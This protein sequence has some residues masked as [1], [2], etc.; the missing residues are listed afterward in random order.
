MLAGDRTPLFTKKLLALTV[1]AAGLASS[2][3]I[4]PPAMAATPQFPDLKVLPPRDLE[5]ARVNVSGG[6]TSAS[7]HHNV[8]RF[9]NTVWNSGD[10]DLRMRGV[11][12]PGE[13]PGPAFQRVMDDAGGFTERTA[14]SMVFHQQHDHYHYEGWGLYQLWT[15]A[16][17]DGWVSGGK[18]P[19]TVET[20]GAKTTSC[21]LDEEFIGGPANTRWPQQYRFSGCLANKNGELHEGLAVG[22]GDTYDS[23]RYDQ[24]IDLGATATL[25]DGEYVLRSV[26]DPGNQIWESP[27]GTDATREATANN[28]SIQRF[29]IAGG[30][31][32]DEDAPTGTVTLDDVATSTSDTSVTLKALGRDDVSGT[33]AFRVSNDNRTWS[34]PIA[35]SGYDSTPHSLAWNLADPQYGGNANPGTK[36]VYVQFRDAANRWGASETDT[37]DLV[38][39]GP[40]T[41]YSRTVRDDG[42]LSHWRLDESVATFGALDE[43]GGNHG[44][45]GGSPVIGAAGLLASEPDHKAVAFDGNGWLRFGDNSALDLTNRITLEAWV[46]P[47]AYPAGT[48]FA[49][50]LSKPEAYSLQFFGSQMEFTVITASGTSRGLRERLRLP[51]GAVPLN[52]VSHLV[53]TYDGATQ[54]LYVNGELAGERPLTLPAQATAT[55]IYVGSWDGTQEFFRG[56]IDEPAVY[57]TALSQSRT[58]AHYDAGK[59]AATAPAA[60]TNLAAADVSSS[61][62]DLTWTDNASDE[63]AF[64]LQRS[65]N[66]AFTDPVPIDVAEDRQAHSDTGLEPNRQYWYRILARNPVGPSNWSNVATAATRA[67]PPI[68]ENGAPG[69]PEE[70]TATVSGTVDPQGSATT[71]RFEYGPDFSSSTTAASAGSG[72]TAAPVTASLAGLQ[73]ATTYG[74]RLVATNSAGSTTSTSTGTFKTSSPAPTA[75]AAV[76]AA[77]TQV[78]LSWTDNSATETGFAAQRATD[79]SFSDAVDLPAV[80]GSSRSDAGL[81]PNK[82]YWYRVRA[83]FASGGES[84]WSAAQTV[85]TP[86]ATPTAS[87]SAASGVDETAGT[88]N[89]RV[90]PQGSATSY[91]FEHRRAGATSWSAGPDVAAGSGRANVA[92]TRQVT[93]LEPTTRYEFRIAATNSAGTTTSAPAGTFTTASPGAPSGLAAIAAS[94]TRIDLSWTDN[95]ISESGFVVE[96]ATDDGFTG[97]VSLPEVAGTTTSDTGLDPNRTYWY[98]VRARLPSGTTAWSGAA[99]RTT[100]AAPPTAVTGDAAGVTATGAT[101]AGS[102]DPRGAATTWWFEYGTG[103][104]GSATAAVPGGSGRTAT[105]AAATLSGLDPATKYQ[106]RLV[107]QNAGGIT[108]GL[109]RVFTTASAPRDEQDSEPPPAPPAATPPAPPA[110]APGPLPTPDAQ[111]DLRPPRAAVG[112]PR[113]TLRRALRRGLSFRLKSS[114]PGRAST[115]LLVPPSSLAR[116]GR[117][118]ELAVGRRTTRITHAGKTR[119]VVNLSSPARRLLARRRSVKLWVVTTVSDRSG[120]RSKPV[121]TAVTLRAGR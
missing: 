113:Q 115:V 33:N 74:Y 49:S 84:A 85:T 35:Y 119:I 86:A 20:T 106:Y 110:Q 64:V 21:I 57:G 111:R 120:N 99:S 47:T 67:A 42:P 79:S 10:G 54:R 75:L 34:A 24:W 16:D 112:I 93:G 78:N 5:L 28:D 101:L 60:P 19:R 32:V 62:I 77:P 3:L 61:R 25:A 58:R 13:Q 50:V 53:G 91:R 59:P 40:G 18:P 94:P 36:T 66:S 6:D 15:A 22:W 98:R 65:E 68:V 26:I 72:R 90:N 117:Q 71:Y 29:R 23:W 109:P 100:P 116:H 95:S 39:P 17:Y 44:Q 107:A 63:S 76:P 96:R 45:Y 30:K 82:T 118:G 38:G 69:T 81:E 43:V 102:A 121:R 103:D 87:T 1:A 48:G 12:G 73:G 56:T 70:T 92:A 11:P 37:I 89:G 52:Q 31:L 104:F 55:G 80:A 7:G 2:A 46:K 41:T 8:L 9:S 4:S 83:R 88:L 51:A 108:R 14:G 105:P 97:A 114:E 27:G